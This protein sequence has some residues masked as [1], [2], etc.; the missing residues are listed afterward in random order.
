MKITEYFFDILM[1]YWTVVCVKMKAVCSF[2][3]LI[4]IYKTT[5]HHNPEDHKWHLHRRE[6]LNSQSENSVRILTH[7]IYTTKLIFLC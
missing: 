4:T 6:N 7:T 3:I 1:L 5:R 2:E